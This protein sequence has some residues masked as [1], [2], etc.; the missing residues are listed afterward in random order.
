MDIEAEETVD[1][2]VEDGSLEV[3]W[4]GSNLFAVGKGSVVARVEV[5]NTA[6]STVAASSRWEVGDSGVGE[7]WSLSSEV[8]V[9]TVTAWVSGDVAV[10]TAVVEVLVDG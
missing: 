9:G 3:S 7:V 2:S 10:V 5:V 6:S 4:V 8:G 1:S